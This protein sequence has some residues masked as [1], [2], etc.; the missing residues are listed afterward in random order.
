MYLTASLAAVAGR[1][2]AGQF[3][4][5][6]QIA[7]A[8]GLDA[9]WLGHGT[10]GL[11]LDPL[12]ILGSLIAVT[13][14]I[15][16]GA[17][18]SLDHSEPFHVARVFCTLDHLA[19][20]RTAWLFG[21]TDNPALFRHVSPRVGEAARERAAEFVDVVGQLWDSWE[22]EA[23]LLDVPSGRFADPARVHPIHHAG[24]HFTVRGPL[25]VPRPPQGAPVLAQALSGGSMHPAAEV[26]L[27][28]A[29][30][31]AGAMRQIRALASGAARRVLV[32]LLPGTSSDPLGFMADAI[33]RGDC[34]G[35]NLVTTGP[36]TL[37]HFVAETVPALR[38][39][40]LR[41]PG[42]AGGTLRDHLA[43]PRSRSRFA[44]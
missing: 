8:G 19:S 41:P 16:L 26:L 2:L 28:A 44:A 23:F 36:E 34:H 24:P 31:A 43:L 6:V 13:S 38:S 10:A 27:V 4:A 5:M 21:Q 30:A 1:P 42:Y 29:A 20:G 12:P 40:G 18:W 7:E 17:A 11:V 15:G 32:N 3:P 22:D 9:V 39:Q 14:R 37:S 35:F 25:N 33:A